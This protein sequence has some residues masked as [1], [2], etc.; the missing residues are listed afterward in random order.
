LKLASLKNKS[1]FDL[2]FEKNNLKIKNI[3]KDNFFLKIE[4]IIKPKEKTSL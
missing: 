1:D 2:I 3:N 4:G